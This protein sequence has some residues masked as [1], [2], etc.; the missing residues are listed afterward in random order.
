MRRLIALSSSLVLL[1]SVAI[2]PQALATPAS[3]VES[4]TLATGHLPAVSSMTQTG[5]WQSLIW[6]NTDSTLTVTENDVAPGGTFGWHEHPGPSLVVVETGTLTFYD[7]DDPSCAPMTETA[8]DA[9]IDPG[10]HLHM[11]VNKGT[12][13]AVVLVTRLTPTDAKS[14]R[15]DEDAP[16]QCSKI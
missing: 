1:A 13:P 7:G 14:A 12:D 11:G 2:A 9:F 15:I 5:P 3:G 4:K 16:S 6:T 8:G 10:N